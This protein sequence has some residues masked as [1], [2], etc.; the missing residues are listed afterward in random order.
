M[1]VA[2][3]GGQ[4]GGDCTEDLNDQSQPS[5]FTSAPIPAY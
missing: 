2:L 1:G 3:K 5:P 4:G